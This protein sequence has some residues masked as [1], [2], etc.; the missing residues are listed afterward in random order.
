MLTSPAVTEASCM[1]A[2]AWPSGGAAP[3]QPASIKAAS[4]R[5]GAAPLA[6]RGIAVVV[7]GGRKLPAAFRGPRHRARHKLPQTALLERGDRCVGGAPGGG[8]PAPELGRRFTGF[9]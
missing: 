3:P 1:V 6:A 8:D 7:M 4:S 9:G 5:P 2:L